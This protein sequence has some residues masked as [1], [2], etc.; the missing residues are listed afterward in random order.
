MAVSFRKVRRRAPNWVVW[1]RM[2]VT[3]KDEAIR[4]AIEADM[5]TVETALQY[6]MSYD[7]GDWQELPK[8]IPLVEE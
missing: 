1:M 2:G 5:W 4:R 6:R 8:D 3:N 7:N